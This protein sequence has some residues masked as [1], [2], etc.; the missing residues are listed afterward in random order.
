M[1]KLQRP[2]SRWELT[3]FLFSQAGSL[4]CPLMISVFAR[5]ANQLL[6]VAL[7]VVA[8]HGVVRVYEGQEVNIPLLLTSLILVALLKAALRYLEHYAGHWVAFSSLH[9]LRVSFFSSLVPQAPAATQGKA[10][11]DLSERA[12]SD[13][14]RIEVFFAHTF[15]PAV[16]AIV[17]PALVIYWL[18][19]KVSAALALAI[20][21]GTVFLVV[22][23]PV[24]S[25]NLSWKNAQNMAARRGDIAAELGDNIQGIREILAFDLA[26]RRLE[27][28]TVA[29]ANLNRVRM[30]AA[31][32]Q[33]LRNSLQVLC[34]TG[35][36]VAVVIVASYITVTPG[37]LAVALIATVSLWV[38]VTGIDDFAAG[39]DAAFAATGRIYEV[40][41]APPLVTEVEV[42]QPFPA[43][44]EIVIKNLSFGYCDDNQVI[45]DLSAVFSFG[46][47]TC[48]VGVSGSGKSTLANLILRGW[49]ITSGEIEVGGIS[50]SQ[51]ALADLRSNIGLVGQR[52]TLLSGSLAEN[53]R[54]RKPD[55]TENELRR[56][57][58][59]VDLLDWFESLPDGFDTEIAE[60]G[61]SLSGGQLQRLCLART[62]VS[63]PQILI[64]DEALS[65]LD[66][67]TARIVRE[68][69][70]QEN[71]TVI[72]ITHRVDAIPDEI[73][74][75]VLD[76][77]KIV[78]SG[79]AAELRAT[80]VAFAAIAN[81]V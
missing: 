60:R 11:A 62:L 69:L 65:Q 19:A 33:A 1:S 52:D 64:I 16:S 48:L 54:L 25:L 6:T 51:F 7:L 39:L 2:V 40:I 15:P 12:V 67:R 17:V 37:Q 43:Q 59:V 36:L 56:A 80:G 55:A 32:I 81:R 3:R 46:A 70:A 8:G 10:G 50:I 35:N 42:P 61:L 63:Q 38:P 73:P 44:P 22:I 14:D 26:Q 78:E 41:T 47:W 18:A 49:N 31:W 45:Q 20:V 21:P 23:L 76:N 5:I 24:I 4:T 34:Q 53:L 66:E 75:L 30:R 74:V 27:S 71:L 28:M 79:S 68:R 72:E 57:L 77:G 29:D 58:G 13:I 9:R